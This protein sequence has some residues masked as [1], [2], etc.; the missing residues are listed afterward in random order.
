M[1]L[2]FDSRCRLTAS[3]LEMTLRAVDLIDEIQISFWV[4]LIVAASEAAVCSTLLTEDLADGRQ[5]GKVGVLNPFAARWT[6]YTRRSRHG[7]SA[8]P[9]PWS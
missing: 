5:Y 2:A 1:L 7:A 4:A 3:S 6:R 8:A 9:G